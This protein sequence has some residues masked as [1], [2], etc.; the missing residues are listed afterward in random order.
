MASISFQPDWMMLDPCQN[1]PN[2]QRDHSC[3]THARMHSQ[4]DVQ[5][6]TQASTFEGH[7]R[8]VHGEAVQARIAQLARVSGEPRRGVGQHRPICRPDRPSRPSAH[9][10]SVVLD[11][12]L[13]SRLAK[14][15]GRATPGR[16]PIEFVRLRWESNGQMR[17]SGGTT[18]EGTGQPVA[19]SDL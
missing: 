6:P 9:H 12:V 14:R 19:T 1:L 18:L 3:G 10:R 16:D 5:L 8:E 15:P 2:Q 13:S 17:F 11:R 4:S 7:G